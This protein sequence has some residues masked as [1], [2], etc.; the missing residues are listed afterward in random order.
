M[1][2][3]AVDAIVPL[4]EKISASPDFQGFMNQRGFGMIFAGPCRLREVHGG[5]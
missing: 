5:A 3:E 1:P 2:K 4:L